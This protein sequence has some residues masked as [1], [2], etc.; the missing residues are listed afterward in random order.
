MVCGSVDAAG[1]EGLPFLHFLNL[2]PY[3]IRT[4]MAPVNSI[5]KGV[6]LIAKFVVILLFLWLLKRR[7]L[8]VS[9]VHGAAVLRAARINTPHQADQSSSPLILRIIL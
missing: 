8:V 4:K 1:N 7:K 5:S 6:Y 3:Q 9:L 2:V